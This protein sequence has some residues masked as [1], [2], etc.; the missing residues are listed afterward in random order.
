MLADNFLL[1]THHNGEPLTPDH[2]YPLR[3]L[4]GAVPGEKADVDRYL[5]KGG[6]W[7]RRLEFAAS[8]APGFWERN[9]YSNTANVWREERYWR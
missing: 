4:M 8:D 3:G 5:W 2:G 1:A 6:K 7:L 9:G